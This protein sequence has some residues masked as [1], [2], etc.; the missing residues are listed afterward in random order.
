MALHQHYYSSDHNAHVCRNC[1][2]LSDYCS[3]AT[4]E[5][6]PAGARFDAEESS[7]SSV[8]EGVDVVV[9]RVDRRYIMAVDDSDG[10]LGIYGPSEDYVDASTIRAALAIAEEMVREHIRW[11]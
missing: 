4:G 6:V 7:L 1:N 8:V 2:C 9:Y 10:I 3:E 11:R 5:P